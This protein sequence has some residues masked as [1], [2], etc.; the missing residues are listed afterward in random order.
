MSNTG[1]APGRKKKPGLGCQCSIPCDITAASPVSG[2]PIAPASMSARASSDAGAEHRV[3][4]HADP[5]PFRL[6]GSED[7]H[8]V[9][10][11]GG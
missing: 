4:R 5:K 3:R 6:G 11:R 1:P 7:R 2:L 8:A 9:G 10:D